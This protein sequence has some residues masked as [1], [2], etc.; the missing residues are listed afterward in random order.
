MR[1]G[2]KNI[3][4]WPSKKFFHPFVIPTV[5]NL[6]FCQVPQK[7][8]QCKKSAAVQKTLQ[9]FKNDSWDWKLQAS[10]WKCHT[11]CWNWAA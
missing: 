2:K 3:K 7:S 1:G 10:S 6:S 9:S 8:E 4:K 5:Q 11:M